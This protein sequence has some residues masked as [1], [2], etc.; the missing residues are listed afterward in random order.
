MTS[1]YGMTNILC[2]WIGL[3]KSR[4]DVFNRID[5]RID[6]FANKM[7]E[8]VDMTGSTRSS[9]V[10][11]EIDGASVVT[12]KDHGMMQI[13]MKFLNDVLD[14]EHFTQTYGKSNVICFS[15]QRVTAGCILDFQ[16]TKVSLK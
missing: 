9:I 6:V 14:E 16:V 7:S 5:S 13:Q 2:H 3:I 15:A 12:V 4:I 10:V 8:N 11:A 1:K